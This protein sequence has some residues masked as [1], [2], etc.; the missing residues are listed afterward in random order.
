MGI[1]GSGFI[2]KVHTSEYSNLPGVVIRRVF[3]IR[4]EKARLLAKETS[5]IVARLLMNSCSISSL[6]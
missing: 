2:G 6:Q 1:F 4:E 3:D 5:P